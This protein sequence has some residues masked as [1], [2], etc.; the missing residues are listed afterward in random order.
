[1]LVLIVDVTPLVTA[2][3]ASADAAARQAAEAATAREFLEQARIS[4]PLESMG[5]AVLFVDHQGRVVRTKRDD[6]VQMTEAPG[7][8]G[9]GGMAMTR[10]VF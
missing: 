9:Q 5:E 8:T 3:R 6:A 7:G 4:A 1:M 10:R 2:Q